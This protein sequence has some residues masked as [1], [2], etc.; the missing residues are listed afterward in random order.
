MPRYILAIVL[1]LFVIAIGGIAFTTRT[2]GPLPPLPPSQ[3]E[4]TAL[5]VAN[6][7]GT[8]VY[9]VTGTADSAGVTVATSTGTEQASGRAVPMRYEVEMT[10][11]DFVYLS[12]QNEGVSGTI[13]CEISVG[14]VV[15]SR[16]TSAGGYTI[17][18][19]QGTVP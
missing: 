14:G 5:P 7:G 15:I 16:N 1:V 19:C 6:P 11:G 8:V 13:T 12:A 4:P 10:P 18:S 9:A 3:T 17:A 2:P